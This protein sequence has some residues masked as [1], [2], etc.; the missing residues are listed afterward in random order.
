[1]AAWYI[2][3]PTCYFSAADLAA[4]CRQARGYLSHLGL[5]G[6]QTQVIW[7]RAPRQSRRR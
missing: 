3:L 7:P 4:L 5:E 1:M 6:F 2:R